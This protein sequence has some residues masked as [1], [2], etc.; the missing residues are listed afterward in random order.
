M[1][2]IANTRIKSKGDAIVLQSLGIENALGIS[3]ADISLQSTAQESGPLHAHI[4]LVDVLVLEPPR[5]WTFKTPAWCML[6]QKSGLQ[7]ITL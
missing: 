1:V 4:F 6:V 2:P 3:T 7:S 5:S